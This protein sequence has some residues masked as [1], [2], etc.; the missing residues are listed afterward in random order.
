MHQAESRSV[1]PSLTA[2]KSAT[3]AAFSVTQQD[4]VSL[5]RHREVVE[6]RFAAYW[7]ARRL[8]PMSLPQIG[9]AFGDRDHTTIMHGLARVPGM[10]ESVPGF[11]ARLALAESLID[12]EG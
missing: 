7:L 11:G 1:A 2:I 6:A 4:I 9:R 12:G 3:A 10:R 5:R 8:T